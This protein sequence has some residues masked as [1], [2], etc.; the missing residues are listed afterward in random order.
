[1]KF[2]KSGRRIRFTDTSGISSSVWKKIF[3]RLNHLNY[4]FH[5]EEDVKKYFDKHTLL[6]EDQSEEV[7]KVFNGEHDKDMYPHERIQR[8]NELAKAYFGTTNNFESSGYILIDGSMLNFS[9]S[10]RKRDRDHREIREAITVDSDGYSDALIQF[11]NYG[12]VR[13]SSS[14][15]DIAKRPT[16][17]QYNRITAFINYIKCKRN[18]LYIDISDSSGSCVKQFCYDNPSAYQVINDI[19]NYF[20]IITI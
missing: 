17:A 5:D 19:D 11:M 15:L 7:L 16:A 6:N 18:S 3:F 12:N 14:G 10:G 1:M 8:E 13:V 2:E 20:D 9:Y 4:G